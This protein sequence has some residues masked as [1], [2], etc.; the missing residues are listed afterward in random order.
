MK[1]F[2]SLGEVCTIFGVSRT[3]IARWEEELGFPRRVYLG[4][5]RPTRLRNGRT[6]R[7]NCRI[8]YPEEEVIA[9]AQKRMDERRSPQ[10]EA[11]ELPDQE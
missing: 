2:L 7:S 10:P 5:V 9:W 8:G 11:D 6:K 3:T 4:A 1:R